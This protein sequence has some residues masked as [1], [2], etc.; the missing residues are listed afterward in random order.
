MSG[1]QPESGFRLNSEVRSRV[2]PFYDPDALKHFLSMLPER[3]RQPLLDEI[4]TSPG[5]D[6]K[7]IPQFG[8]L[9]PDAVALKQILRE[10][11]A[12]C[13]RMFPELA[14]THPFEED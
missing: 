8:G 2:L 5:A 14:N 4:F 3:E 12:P 7:S 9:G 13:H 10:V 1:D 11:F 6:N